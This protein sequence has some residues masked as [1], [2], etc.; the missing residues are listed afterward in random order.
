MVNT[1]NVVDQVTFRNHLTNLKEDNFAKT[2]LAKCNMMNLW[3]DCYGIFEGSELLCAMVIT[4]SK[5]NPRI[6]N[7][8]LIHTFFK[9]RGKGAAKSLTMTL[10]NSMEGEFDYLRVSAEKTAVGF[11]EKL[12]FKFL[13]QQK[14][15]T[16]LSVFKATSTDIRKCS[17]DKNDPVIDKMLNRKGKGGCVIIF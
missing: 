6:A 15:G 11:Y 2:F 17:F 14:S 16:L 10:L 7:L 13:G 3:E 1:I 12:G 5:S 8:Q 9:H 4:V